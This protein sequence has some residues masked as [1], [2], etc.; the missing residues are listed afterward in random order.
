MYSKGKVVPVENI[1]EGKGWEIEFHPLLIFALDW[2]G[3]Q[4]HAQATSPNIKQPKT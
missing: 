3:C 2:V 4:H 1:K